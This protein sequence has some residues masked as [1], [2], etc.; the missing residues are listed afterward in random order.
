MTTS[1]AAIVLGLCVVGTLM[2]IGAAIQLLS[3]RSRV[4]LRWLHLVTRLLSVSLMGITLLLL[5]PRVK[6]LLV[7]FGTSLPYVGMPVFTLSDWAC[8]GVVPLV[9]FGLVAVTAEMLF[10]EICLRRDDDEQLEFARL[11]SFLVIIVLA[12]MLLVFQFGTGM[13]LIKLANDLS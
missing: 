12:L 11:C 3:A 6:A 1:A 5:A 4:A 2:L 7:G 13:S 10:L 8:A 9:L